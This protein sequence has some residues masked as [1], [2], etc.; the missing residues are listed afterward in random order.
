MEQFWQNLVMEFT[1]TFIRD[2]RWKV[3]W[4]GFLNTLMITV[5]A[6]LIGIAIGAAITG[7]R[8]LFTSPRVPKRRRK[9]PWAVLW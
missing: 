7:L 4:S 5:V 3:F 6:A 1:R 8:Y 2:N 9:R